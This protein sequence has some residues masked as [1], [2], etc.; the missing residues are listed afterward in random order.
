MPTPSLDP[1]ILSLV[2]AT[3]IGLLIGT[4]R[5]RRKGEGP[6]R[7][8][9]GLRT[10]TIAS[11]VGAVGF[12]AGRE[13]LLAVIAGG[14]FLLSATAYWRAQREDPGITTAI[15]LVAASL[16]GGLAIDKPV[17]A[18]GIA[19]VVTIV[20]NARSAL[21]RFVRSVLSEDEM[22]DGLIFAAATLIVLPL[23][24]NENIG[25]YEALNP[26]TIWIIV[27]VVMAIG[28]LGHI[29]VRALGARFGLPVAGLAA[30]FVSSAATVNAM[31]A[32]AARE[33]ELLWPAAAGAALSSV[34]TPI[35]MSIFLAIT[36]MDSLRAALIPLICA[37]AAAVAYGLI[38]SI[39]AIRDKPGDAD[40]RG[41]AFS[42]TTAL[43]FAG[44]LGTILLV[45]RILHQFYGEAGVIV[46]SAAAGFASTDPPMISVAS[47]VGAGALTPAQSVLPILFAFTTN[48]IT[49]VIAA[50]TS[51]GTAFA[52]RVVPGLILMTLAA[53]GG[54]LLVPE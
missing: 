19:V 46:A 39:R 42:I 30:G 24:P 54:W 28:G 37:L 41:H 53:W 5:E 52:L 8:P 12:L 27:I 29:A 10:F 23:L 50:M 2:V 11:L 49:K 34:T 33:P 6:E 31:G 7:S 9:A 13:I 16:L 40:Q 17:L 48:T 4:E 38:L 36:N 3:G 47:L 22:R 43:T 18:A 51:G 44:L 25:P 15:S 26:H 20:L 1:I 45:S 32:R 35:Q 21:H 14:I